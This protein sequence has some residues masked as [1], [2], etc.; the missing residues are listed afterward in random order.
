MIDSEKVITGLKCC[1][2][3]F[4]NMNCGNCPYDD[5]TISAC[6]S[7]LTCDALV[8]MEERAPVKPINTKHTIQVTVGLKYE[9]ICGAPLLEG[10]PFCSKCG[11]AMKW[12]DE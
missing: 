5:G 8:L 9:C 2:G 11:K 4:E 6:T 12:N 1:C 3:T 10:Q 7:E